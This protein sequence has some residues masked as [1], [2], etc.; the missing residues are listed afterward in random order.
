MA[1]RKKAKKGTHHRRRRKVGA[2]HPAIMQ[3]LEMAGGAAVGAIA[4]VFINQAIKSSF[5]SAPSWTGGAVCA[6]GGA[7]LPLFI[8]P[9]P[10]VTGAAA[11]LAGVGVMFMLN[12]TFLSLPGISGIPMPT[13]G[14]RPGYINQT[15]GRTQRMVQRV[16]TNR[17]G[18]LSG[19]NNMAIGSLY[20]N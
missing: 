4:G 11:G 8:K 3:T 5:T 6:A 13:G 18:N 9:S 12:E 17:I 14:M 16:P 7:S 20:D 2:V 1:R 15:V 19:K 10:M